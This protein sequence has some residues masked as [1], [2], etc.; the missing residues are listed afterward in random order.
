MGMEQIQMLAGFASTALFV[1]NNFPMVVKAFK[2]KDLSSYSF[3]HI[4]LSNVCNLLL[5]LYIVSLPAGPVWFQ[6]GFFTVATAL[7][8]VWY[9]RHEKDRDQP[10]ARSS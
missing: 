6:H 10:D 4:A 5:A 1:S 3:G 8:L 9:L 7:M 2:T